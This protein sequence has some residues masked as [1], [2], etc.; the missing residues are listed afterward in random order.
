MKI[1]TKLFLSF[2]AMIALLFTLGLFTYTHMKDT[3]A[4]YQEMLGDGDFRSG[5]LNVE[6]RLAGMSNDERA[7]L[8]NRDSQFASSVEQK[9]AE[10]RQQLSLLHN[11][12]TLDASDMEAL[13]NITKSYEAYYKASQQVFSKAKAGSM[14]E[15]Q[16]L[17]FGEERETRKQLDTLVSQLIEKLNVEIGQDIEDRQTENDRQNLLMIAIFAVSLAAAITIGLVLARLITKP[18]SIVNRQLKEISEGH[19]DLSR[20]LELRS[21]DEVGQLAASFN[22]MIRN[23]RSILSQARNT[24]IQVAASSEQLTASAEQT[25]EATEQIVEA[26]QQI[27]TNAEQEQLHVAETVQAIR[28]MSSGID[29][30]AI[31]NEEVSRLAQTASDAAT[32]GTAAVRDVLSEMTDIQAAVQAAASVIESLGAR[33]QQI[34]GITSLIT[35]LAN[36]T[37]LLSLNAAIEAARAGEHGRGFAVVAQEIRK[38]ADQSGK[39]SNQIA[40][41]IGE[42]VQETEQAVAT[43]QAGT[44]KVTAGLAKAALAGDVFQ[45]IEANVTA[46]AQQVEHSST[47][48]LDL[49]ATS[50]HMVSVVERVSE[51]SN[52]VAASC[53]SNSASTEEQLATMEEISSSAQALSKLAEDLH[54]VLS[55]F[56][57]H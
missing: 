52:T 21:R 15:A 51:A 8:L 53:Q 56:K 24:A 40:E 31:S 42:I 4:A 19:G 10:V 29:Q 50:Q 18:L 37:N 41:L 14:N 48:V 33:S 57:L 45:A 11:S 43:M 12:T 2:G 49:A 23:L 54:S 47:T 3:Q 36:R 7:Y 26:T 34:N 16:A 44:G 46:V 38:L 35:D 28:Q 39:S 9:D 55:R 30:V 32:R 17:H 25:T 5:L 6:Y 20:E 13:S 27:A 22:L 1:R